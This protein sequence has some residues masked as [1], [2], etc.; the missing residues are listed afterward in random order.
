MR[1]EAGPGLPQPSM[2]SMVSDEIDAHVGEVPVARSRRNDPMPET[3][4]GRC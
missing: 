1:I 3:R 4:T 2:K